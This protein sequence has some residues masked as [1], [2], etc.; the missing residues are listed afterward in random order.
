MN[1]VAR[2]VITSY[3]ARTPL[4][5]GGG[6]EKAGG[7]YRGVDVARLECVCLAAEGGGAFLNGGRQGGPQ[8]AR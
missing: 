8:T 6:Y 3:P 7:A 1:D 2:T 5:G 4:E